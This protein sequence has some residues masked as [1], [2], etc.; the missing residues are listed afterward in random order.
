MVPWVL[1]GVDHQEA[2]A[3]RE[4]SQ[5]PDLT[6]PASDTV[7]GGSL[8]LQTS[9]YCSTGAG[10]HCDLLRPTKQPINFLNKMKPTRNSK[11]CST[12]SPVDSMGSF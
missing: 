12:S 2:K 8:A 9:C 5:H 6:N 10:C 3:P 11:S 1:K 4:L 7:A